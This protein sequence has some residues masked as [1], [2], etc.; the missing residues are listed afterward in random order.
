MSKNINFDKN[1]PQISRAETQGRRERKDK[2]N[3]ILIYSAF[4]ALKMAASAASRLC[5]MYFGIN[6]GD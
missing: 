1:F 6:Y 4:F 5:A 2:N 3:K